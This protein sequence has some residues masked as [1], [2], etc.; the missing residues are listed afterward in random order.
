MGWPRPEDHTPETSDTLGSLGPATQ[1]HMIGKSWVLA[2][3]MG[4]NNA[5]E[6]ESLYQSQARKLK[7]SPWPDWDEMV[8]VFG[9]FVIFVYVVFLICVAVSQ[10]RGF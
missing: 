9:L 4:S 1:D 6:Y 3:L 8:G 10:L 5:D 2:Q 7:R